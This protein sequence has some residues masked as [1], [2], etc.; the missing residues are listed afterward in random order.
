M[1]T[2]HVAVV[3]LKKGVVDLTIPLIFDISKTLNW[4]DACS[5][6]EGNDERAWLFRAVRLA[7]YSGSSSS[8]ANSSSTKSEGLGL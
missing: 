7:S 5:I 2:C 3:A 1:I 6:K 8:R 4:I